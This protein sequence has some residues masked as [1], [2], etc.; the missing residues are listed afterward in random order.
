MEMG[1]LMDLE[2]ARGGSRLAL[3]RA[4]TQVENGT[5]FN[6]DEE[7]FILGVTGAPGVGK[8]CLV[9]QLA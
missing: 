8:S 3:S 2:L 9:D 4:L 7:G 5:V 1:R 6:T